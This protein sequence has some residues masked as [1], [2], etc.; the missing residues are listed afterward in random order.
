MKKKIRPDE[1][2]REL[3]KALF[4]FLKRNKS[5]FEEFLERSEIESISVLCEQYNA[6]QENIE[7]L[8]SDSLG[9]SAI[10]DG[11]PCFDAYLRAF[12]RAE[13]KNNLWK[14]RPFLPSEVIKDTNQFSNL[15]FEELVKDSVNI[16]KKYMS[17]RPLERLLVSIDLTRS[18]EAIL[19]EIKEKVGSEKRLI[20]ETRLRWLPKGDKLLEVWDLYDQAGQNPTTMTFKIISKKVGRPLSTVKSQWYMAYEKIFG[21]AYDPEIKYTSEEK[22][23]DATKLCAKCPHEAKCYRKGDW[24]PCTDYLKIAGKERQTPNNLEFKD[25]IYK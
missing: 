25:E 2:S 14:Q 4:E 16:V 18:T 11:E 19:S 6:T 10:I 15:Y 5:K 1:Q 9:M 24:Y 17:E 3:N 21:K 7:D 22:K 8:L 13:K 12:N 20:K 23:T